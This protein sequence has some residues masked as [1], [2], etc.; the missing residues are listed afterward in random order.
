MFGTFATAIIGVTWAVAYAVRDSPSINWAEMAAKHGIVL[1][2][3]VSNDLQFWGEN[4]LLTYH[5]T[6]S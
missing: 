2:E 6:P 3:F 1:L 4:F 5:L